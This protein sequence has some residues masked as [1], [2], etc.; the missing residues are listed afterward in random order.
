MKQHQLEIPGADAISGGPRILVEAVARHHEDVLPKLTH[1]RFNKSSSVDITI[2]YVLSRLSAG[3]GGTQIMEN[4]N[5]P[6]QSKSPVSS[7]ISHIN[8]VLRDGPDSK[9]GLNQL[10]KKAVN[11]LRD[12]FIK[13]STPEKESQK[14]GRRI[15]FAL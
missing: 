10:L 7:T 3:E 11:D 6:Y 8:A 9:R 15:C 14:V 5:I 1:L 4:L 13:I 2:A 12:Q